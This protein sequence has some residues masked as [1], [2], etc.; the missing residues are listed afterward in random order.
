M[1]PEYIFS[2]ALRMLRQKGYIT[3][4]DK[5]AYMSGSIGENGGTTFLEINKVSQVFDRSYE[6]H[7]PRTAK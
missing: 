1:S 5:I 3:Q 2:A 6:F 7:L 4:E